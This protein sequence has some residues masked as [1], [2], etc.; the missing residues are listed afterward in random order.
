MK[1]CE[2]CGQQIDPHA[3]VCGYCG[4]PQ[5]TGGAAPRPR[6]QSRS[7]GSSKSRGG[8]RGGG[9]FVSMSLPKFLMFLGA[10]TVFYAMFM[11][12]FS[13]MGA[14][15]GYRTSG[16]PAVALGW[17]ATFVALIALIVVLVDVLFADL[18]IITVGAAA[19]QL[20]WFIVVFIWL[21]VIKGDVGA[22]V[23]SLGAGFWFYLLGTLVL[24]AGAVFTF[25]GGRRR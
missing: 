11:P 14:G 25:L 20:V 8:K 17:I 22:G 7:G 12:A 16:M 10:V 23:A 15:A 1:F 5:A 18:G 9:S 21:L 24:T 19:L 2:N 6:K 4:A 13:M 3:P